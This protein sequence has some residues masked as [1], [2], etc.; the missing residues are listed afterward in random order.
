MK[1][2]L[3]K[4]ITVNN[5]ICH[6]KP[7]IRNMRYPVT[8]ILELMSAGMTE[9]EILSDYPSLVKEDLQACLLFASKLSDVKTISKVLLR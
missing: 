3:L 9:L 4:R 7:T 1:K 5:D 8:T 2:D 6:G